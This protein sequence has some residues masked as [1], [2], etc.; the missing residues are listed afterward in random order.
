MSARSSAEHHQRDALCPGGHLANPLGAVTASSFPPSWSMIRITRAWLQHLVNVQVHRRT[1]LQVH[2]GWP[3][4]R[5]G[6]PGLALLRQASAS[7]ARCYRP[8]SG[9]P[10]RPGSAEVGPEVVVARSH[11]AGPPAGASGGL[12]TL[13]HGERSRRSGRRPGRW[14][15]NT[16][17]VAR[18]WS[19][20]PAAVEVAVETRAD[21]VHQQTHRLVRAGPRSP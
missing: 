2:G 11:R 3:G 17:R 16:R 4:A 19:A 18:H 1:V 14:P 15:M 10:Y 21:A 12:D 20:T 8:H 6:N 7:S 5:S 13:R 9:S